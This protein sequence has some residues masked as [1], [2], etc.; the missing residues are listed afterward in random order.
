[1]WTNRDGRFRRALCIFRKGVNEDT[2]L[3]RFH[4]DNGFPVLAGDFVAGTGLDGL[5]VPVNVIELELDKFHLR[6]LGQDF[7]EQ[8]GAV[9]ERKAHAAE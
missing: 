4:N 1:M 3:D 5:A 2:A 6:V 7:V 9:M 8:F